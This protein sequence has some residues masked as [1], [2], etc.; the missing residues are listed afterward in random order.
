MIETY[1]PLYRKY[2]PQAFAD[3]VGQG[4]IV[5]TMGNAMTLNKVAHAYLFCGPRGTG[6]TSTARIFAKSLNCEQGPTL[7]P[8]QTCASCTGITAGNAL[9]VIEFDA[10]SNNGVDDA[11][12]LIEN[13]QFTAMAGKFKIYIIDEVHMLSTAAFNTLLKTLE[14]PPPNVIFI[15][16]TTEAHKVLPTI[17]SRCQRFDFN[18][19]TTADITARLRQIADT[20]AIQIDAEALQT[21]ARHARG[22]MRDAVGL[23]DQVSV[24]SRADQNKTIT[25]QDVA[26]FIG[27]L[28]E[29]VLM[30]LTEA[31]AQR[32]ANALLEQVAQLGNRG[33]E[34]A[35][36]VKELTAHF[37]NLL[38]VAACGG[39]VLPGQ[40]DLPPDYLDKL[41]T[42]QTRFSVDELPQLLSKLS[43]IERNIRHTQ[44]PVL[45]LEVG[46]L[47]LAYRQDIALLHDLSERV[48]ALE[49]QLAGGAAIAARPAS[50][51]ASAATFAPKPVP[52]KPAPVENKAAPIPPSSAKTFAQPAPEA[53]AALAAPASGLSAAYEAICK[54]VASPPTKAILQQ[55]TFLV[56]EEEHKITVGCASSAILELL[57]RP[58]KTI[59]LKK[60][61]EKYY[62]REIAVEL[63]LEKMPEGQTPVIPAK[64]MVAPIAP[65]N[66]MP[67]SPRADEEAETPVAVPHRASRTAVLPERPKAESGDP[68]LA[69]ARQHAIDMLQGRVLE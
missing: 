30:A 5:Q 12:E 28:E 58:D 36:L 66:E 8:C 10:A 50:P 13:C 60:A 23:L 45:W 33:V 48:A 20:E 21:I 56:S 18:R 31:I 22:G 44:Q 59:H 34:P 9:D 67:A 53:P 32:D 19:I 43:G 2:R 63:I 1:I 42:Q 17:I 41:K 26:L 49:A 6:K 7:A 38:V 69:E 15:F 52:A 61:A 39:A 35:Q 16:A 62:D 3:V 24:L 40:L 51:S 64:P 55:Q 25:R 29:D 47:E 65:V 46:L 37:R 27:A 4:P 68:D 57:K 14:E 11:R 54:K